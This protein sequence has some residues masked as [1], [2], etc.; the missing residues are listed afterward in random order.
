MGDRADDAERKAIAREMQQNGW[1]YVPHCIL[2]SSS[3]LRLRKNVTGVI[4]MPEWWASGTEEGL[5]VL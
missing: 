4:G 5:D 1:D 2:G 3:Q